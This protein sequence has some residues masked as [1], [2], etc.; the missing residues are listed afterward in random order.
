[1]KLAVQAVAL[2]APGLPTWSAAQP[3]LARQGRYEP[4]PSLIPPVSRLPATERRRVGLSVKVA[5]ALAEQLFATEGVTP[6][7]DTATLFTS[8]GGDGENCHILCEALQEP[9]PALSPTR[10]TNSVHNAPAGYWSIAA[11][12]RLPSTS[13]CAFDGSFVAGLLEAAVYVLS[14][15][16][17][18]A[19]I[20]YDVPYPEPLNG[21]RPIAAPAGV[22]LL[23]TPLRAGMPAVAVIEIAGLAGAAETP[24]TEPRLEALRLGVPALR[25]LPLLTAMAERLPGSVNIGGNGGEVLPVRVSFE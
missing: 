7:A 25:A 23:L 17:P 6:P 15:Q 24:M 13:L 22:A 19:L 3:V 4:A 1:M 11:Q 2:I 16:A 20:A 12:C 10:F 8:S 9:Q 5:L 18:L 14:E 21:K